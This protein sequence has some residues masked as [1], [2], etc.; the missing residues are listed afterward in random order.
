MKCTGGQIKAFSILSCTAC[1][2]KR[3]KSGER[4]YTE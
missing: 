2:A 1:D 4:Q 3:A